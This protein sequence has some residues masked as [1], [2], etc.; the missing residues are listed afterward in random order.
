MSPLPRRDVLKLSAAGVALA[1]LPAGC[2]S[3]EGPGPIKLGRDACDFCGM[4]VSE[5]RY[6]AEIRGGPNNKLFKFDDVGCAVNFTQR[7]AWA[8]EPAAKFWAMS[9]QDGATWLDA[10]QAAYRQG[11]P[12][13]MGYGFA[14]VPNGADTVP[15]DAMKAAALKRTECAPTTTTAEAGETR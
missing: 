15:F 12:T 4:I 1:W 7:N 3:E 6:A 14:A 10:R 11:L 2:G 9:H 13:P 5:L 8:A